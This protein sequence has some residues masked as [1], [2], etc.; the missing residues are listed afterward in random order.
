LLPLPAVTQTPPAEPDPAPPPDQ[1]IFAPAVI[2]PGPGRNALIPLTPQ[3]ALDAL[4]LV[5]AEERAA[6]LEQLRGDLPDFAERVQL[7]VA[8]ADEIIGLLVDRTLI[9]R[10]TSL[11]VRAFALSGPLVDDLLQRLARIEAVLGERVGIYGTYVATLAARRRVRDY[12]VEL[13]DEDRLSMEQKELLITA[14]SDAERLQPPPRA[15]WF[16]V[17]PIA[18]EQAE[19]AAKRFDAERQQ[20]Y[21]LRLRDLTREQLQRVSEVLTPRQFDVFFHIEAERLDIERAY[22]EDLRL[23]AGLE[24]VIPE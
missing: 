8:E 10:N 9:E 11:T 13:A 16:A 3:S 20:Y 24:R 4:R 22:V 6:M 14:L 2:D 7:A 21:F 19:R 18:E 23:A 1:G 5:P 12:D 15:S 17:L